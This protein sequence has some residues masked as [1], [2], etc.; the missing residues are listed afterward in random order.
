MRISGAL[1]FVLVWIHVAANALLTGAH[2]ITLEFVALRWANGLAWGSTFGILAV[3]LLHGV[4]GLRAVLGDYVHSDTA[5]RVLNVVLL[6]V[7]VVITAL[8]AYAM[9]AGVRVA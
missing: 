1:L 6:L 3:A 7:W 2:H 9:F 5:N 8:G 4:N